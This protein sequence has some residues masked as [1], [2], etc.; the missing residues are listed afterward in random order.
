MQDPDLDFQYIEEEGVFIF[1]QQDISND[2]D[3]MIQSY[4]K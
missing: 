4:I 3:W 1:N 2:V